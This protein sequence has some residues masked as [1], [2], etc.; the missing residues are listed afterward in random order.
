MI[1]AFI[2][3]SS[4]QKRFVKDLVESLGRNYFIVDCYDFEAGNKTIEEIYNK[5][6][7]STVFILF[8]SN[9]SINSDWVKDEIEYAKNKFRPDNYKYFWPFI[10]DSDLTIED[11]PKWI[12]EE[13]CFNLKT[14]TS[15][16][17]LSRIIEQKFRHI[18]WSKDNRRKLID[19][20]MVGRNVDIDKFE[21]IYQSA[22]GMKTRSLVVSG[23]DGVG[24]DMFISKC[25]NKIGYDIE[26]IPFS[27]S[28]DSKEGIE[29]YI[30][31]LNLILQT[32]NSEQLMTV[33]SKSTEDKTKYAVDMT[34]ELL[35]GNTVLTVIDNLACVLPNRAL[36][37]W[38]V[39][40]I[41]SPAFCNKLALFIKC[42][43]SPNTFID[44]DHPRFAIYI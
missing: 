18:I 3:H 40:M 37:D 7:S 1:R 44:T 17:V 16:K 39:D 36:A 31:Q 9:E 19:T 29:D 14:F 32:Y 6:D 12:R 42:R 41:E 21:D 26:T 10:I 23:R 43:K 2:S 8:L 34:N 20:L 13:E 27:I 15:P 35:S 30:V 11:C 22:R 5:I 24:K 33:L 25:L 4:K 28:L 38:L